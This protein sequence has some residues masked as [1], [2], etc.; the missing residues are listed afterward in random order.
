MRQLPAWM[1]PRPVA[2]PAKPM[3]CVTGQPAR[4]RDPKTGLYHASAAAF[5]QIRLSQGL[6]V[7][8]PPLPQVPVQAPGMLSEDVAAL[9]VDFCQ[10]RSARRSL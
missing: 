1:R 2:P 6:P 5:K 8:E 3:C 4:Y 9:L 7:G 10:E